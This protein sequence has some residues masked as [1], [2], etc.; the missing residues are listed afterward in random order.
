VVVAAHPADETVGATSLLLRAGRAAVVHVTDGAPR[1]PGLRPGRPDRD[2]YARL[3]RREALE[4]LALAGVAPLDA[5]ALGAVDQEAVLVVAPLARE[6]AAILAA[7]A[8]RL[9]VTHAFEGG[10]PDHDAT[11]V[12][13]RAALV[14]IRRRQGSG[15]RLVEMTGY[16]MGGGRLVTGAFLAGPPRAIHH[17]LAPDE[18]ERKRRMLDRYAS[19]RA[20]LSV[21][22][23][24]EERFRVAPP[25]WPWPR[26][27]TGPL[28]YEV[29][30]WTTFEAF[31]ARV[32]EGLQALGIDDLEEDPGAAAGA[33]C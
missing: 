11:A 15:P 24:E 23:V 26:P 29:R 19:R 6:L 22:G 33:R 12:A 28:H 8:P 16:H 21:F 3:R 32:L 31:R 14:L 1:E 27:H 17:R 10:H 2:A 5:V 7:R 18:R 4:A 9:V 13:V 20:V 25:L 30:G